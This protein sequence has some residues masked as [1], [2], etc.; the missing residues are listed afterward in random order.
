[1]KRAATLDIP[2]R[3]FEKN[4]VACRQGMKRLDGRQEERVISGADDKHGAQRLP[5]HLKEH[6]MQPEWSP[7]SP[8][9]SS[10][11]NASR[12]TL[13]PSARVH[14]RQDFETS[15]SASGRAQPPERQH[16]QDLTHLPRPSAGNV[17]RSLDGWRLATPPHLS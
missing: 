13:E 14:E 6:A 1:M 11:E 15:F 7:A 2:E 10:R 8:A 9:N 16:S 5:L 4:G 12:T 3:W 17:G